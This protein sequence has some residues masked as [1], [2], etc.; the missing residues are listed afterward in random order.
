ME[1]MAPRD[2]ADPVRS[3]IA[4][5]RLDWSRLPPDVTGPI[6]QFSRCAITGDAIALEVGDV[7]AQGTW[8]PHSPGDAG[9]P[10]TVK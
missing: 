9:H 1:P 3:G 2:D 8:S 7:S 5:T 4:G 6:E 10:A